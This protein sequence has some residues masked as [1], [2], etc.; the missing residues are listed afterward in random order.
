MTKSQMVLSLKGKEGNDYEKG[1]KAHSWSR[2]NCEGER[3]RFTGR[4]HGDPDTGFRD[5]KTDGTRLDDVC[6]DVLT[7]QTHI[8]MS[9]LE[10]KRIR[11]R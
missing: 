9:S 5:T 7:D 6:T 1:N 2:V 3:F 4:G 8:D 10:L 11:I